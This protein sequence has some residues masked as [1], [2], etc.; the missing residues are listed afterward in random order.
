MTEKPPPVD[1]TRRSFIRQL[2]GDVV[3]SM[4]SMLGAAQILQAESMEAAKG[5]LGPD[6][7]P[8]RAG[9]P[10]PIAAETSAVNAGYRA[11]F[12]WDA[13]VI[14]LVDQRRLPD[15]LADLQVRGAADAVTA[16]NDGALVGAQVQAQVAA[17]TLAL[18]ASRSTSSRGFARRATLRGAANAFRQSRRG[19][20][21]MALVLDR[22][23]ALIEELGVDADGP[24]IAAALKTE[25]EA[26]IEEATDDHG[27][28]V[29]HGIG[30]LPGGADTQAHVMVA[31]STG[32]M[33]GGVFGSALSVVTTAHHQ[34]RPIHALVPEGRP[35]LEGSRVAAW[36][37]RQAGVP[38]AIVTDAAA[39]ACIAANEVEAVLVGADRI[40]AAGDVVGSIGSY[41]LALA[42]Q[43]AGIPFLVFAPTTAI[44][45]A[46]ADGD[47]A[48]L[49]EGRP[50]AVLR[51]AGQ[52]TAP[53]GDQARNPA[54]DL[55]PAALVS[56]IVTETGVLRAPFGPALAEAWAA[57][58]LRRSG[59]RGFAVL[60]A[61]TNAADAGAD[62]GV[63]SSAGGEQADAAVRTP[64]DVARPRPDGSPDV[65]PT[66]PHPDGPVA[67]QPESGA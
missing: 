55:V 46:I 57:A 66:L 26:I 39:P 2:A 29:T 58:S 11:P 32:A 34:G 50:A 33:G 44:D 42:A 31:G 15:V 22:M 62:H 1:P 13:D 65:A 24:A 40:T 27:M 37:L 56:A 60:A 8:G 30:V 52:R 64:V 23:L 61:R 49:E 25:A 36:E 16:I 20:A 63:A 17:A 12:R 43:A 6:A 51:F 53:E 14:H 59:A 48:P 21:P 45:P 47:D 7:G 35:G 54:Q 67:G 28:V 19:S 10:P 4:G 5:L 9:G 41:P 38:H 3:T 18:I